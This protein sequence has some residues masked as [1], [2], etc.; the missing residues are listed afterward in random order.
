MVCGRSDRLHVNV[1][2]RLFPPHYLA[3]TAFAPKCVRSIPKAASIVTVSF[4][5]PPPY[6]E[7]ELAS[8]LPLPSHEPAKPRER[9]LTI[10]L[11]IANGQSL[12]LFRP[13][14]NPKF[15]FNPAV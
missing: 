4:A 2:L 10:C 13:G 1:F 11:P 12:C 14:R 5:T 9:Q 3:N 6:W 7:D 8:C 15:R